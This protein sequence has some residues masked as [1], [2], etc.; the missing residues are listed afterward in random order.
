MQ[1]AKRRSVS[2][3]SI[4]DKT[5]LKRGEKSNGLIF[6]L[7]GA[8]SGKSTFA[9]KL[10]EGAGKDV[11]YLATALANDDEMALRISRHKAERPPH[12][13]TVEEP[14]DLKKVSKILAGAKTPVLLDCLTL[15]LSNVVL[16]EV[17]DLKLLYKNEERLARDFSFLADAAIQS[18][19]PVIFVANE[20][21]MGICPENYLG[22]AFRD[23]AGRINQEISKK[24]GEVYFLRA[25][26]PQ[27][28]K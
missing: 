16:N 9:R 1:N 3:Q 22:R 7:G 18:S 12:W 4:K 2:L 20:V 15:L 6:V 8:K 27:K 23:L 28:I 19:Y 13:R 5:R 17:K 10:A 26:I 24:A 21:G 14:C 25:G 11:V